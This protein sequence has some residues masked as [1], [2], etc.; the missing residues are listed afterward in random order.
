MLELDPALDP[1]GASNG[2]MDSVL[3]ASCIESRVG[4]RS[5]LQIQP[6]TMELPLS[7][8]LHLAID[9][10]FDPA[11]DLELNPRLSTPLDLAVDLAVSPARS[12]VV[13]PVAPQ[14]FSAFK[15]YGF[16]CSG[17]VVIFDWVA[18]LLA[19]LQYPPITV[20]V[21]RFHGRFHGCIR[22]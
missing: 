21:S 17:G 8:V 13:D 16:Q 10:A 19:V 6:P 20:S 22:H 2:W 11:L 9:P 12:S 5:N 4:A 14:R 3:V 18:S 15:L 1:L 7:R